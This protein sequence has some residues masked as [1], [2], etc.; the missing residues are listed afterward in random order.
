MVVICPPDVGEP[1]AVMAAEPETTD[2]VPVP[3]PGVF[4]V[5]VAVVAPHGG[6]ISTPAS[7]VRPAGA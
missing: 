4:P 2:H 5:N 1:G 3:E 6:F 7:A